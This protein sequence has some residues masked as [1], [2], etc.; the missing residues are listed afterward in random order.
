MA[1]NFNVSTTQS[2][3]NEAGGLDSNNPAMTYVDFA[4][5]IANNAATQTEQQQAIQNAALMLQQKKQLAASGVNLTPE[6]TNFLPINEAVG[7]LKA[8]GVDDDTI[9]Q[10][11]DSLN[12]Q[13]MVNRASIDT[14]IRKKM[15]SS[16]LSVAGKAFKTTDD[17]LLPPGTNAG[18]LNLVPDP[19]R[20]GIGHVPS[21]GEYQVS[22]DPQSG[23]PTSYIALGETPPEKPNTK[24]ADQLQKRQTDL[25]KLIAKQL[26]ARR[27]NW[28]SQ[29]LYRCSVALQKLNNTPF[30][31]KQDLYQI[32]QDVA[33]IFTGGVPTEEEIQMS[34]Y[35]TSLNSLLDNLTSLTGKVFGL[36]LQ[37]IR[38]KLMSIVQP[39]YQ[40]MI[41]RF[42]NLMDLY[43]QGYPDVI[44]ANPD[45]WD[46]TKQKALHAA[47]HQQSIGS[48]LTTG[49]NLV[50]I[51]KATP[52]G[53]PAAPAAAPMQPTAT[54]TAPAQPPAN[55]PALQ[56][57][58]GAS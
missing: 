22:I 52:E 54:S 10:F 42:T 55:R 40:E 50:P 39:L 15:L 51:G 31:T 34:S 2:Q 57:I 1:D 12:G 7:E 29:G 17:I 41:E 32:A 20:P 13:Q 6:A 24:G 49:G 37:D 4:H 3:A 11:V 58:F 45:W 28:L 8:A 23:Q 14:I 38:S 47:E 5:Q 36:P 43:G 27:G 33:S 30:M 19:T 26:E 21:N 56:D 16:K 9:Q 48:A 46:Q 18:D 53:A 44:Q 35:H 25:V